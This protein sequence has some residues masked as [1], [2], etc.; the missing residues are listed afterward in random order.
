MG[1]VLNVDG[2]TSISISNWWILSND[3]ASP[4]LLSTIEE[5]NSLRMGYEKTTFDVGYIE[6]K[7]SNGVYFLFDYPEEKPF[8]EHNNWTM[9]VIGN[10]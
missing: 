9:T 1:Y 2:G 5:L 6:L 8:E 10:K 7:L 3:K 4:N